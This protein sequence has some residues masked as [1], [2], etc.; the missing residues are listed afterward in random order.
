MA[1]TTW[2]LLCAALLSQLLSSGPA[3]ADTIVH[4][5]FFDGGV[6][7]WTDGLATLAFDLSADGDGF[8]GSG[9]ARIAKLS[10]HVWPE[11]LTQCVDGIQAG[12]TY[13]LEAKVAFAAGESAS[14]VVNSA[15]EFYDL[16]GCTGVPGVSASSPL[17]TTSDGRGKW[18]NLPIGNYKKGIQAG[19]YAQS[20]RIAIE[21]ATANGNTITANVDDVTLAQTGAP[22]CQG[23]SATIVGTKGA[24]HLVGTPG[25]DVI[26]GLGGDDEIDGRGG[27]DIIC[28]GGGVDTISG[29][30]GA[31]QIFGEGG[32]DIL[33][34]G[35]GDDTLVGGDGGDSLSGGRGHDEMDPGPGFDCWDGGADDPANDVGCDLL[36][37]P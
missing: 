6:I 33:K 12:G 3:A 7:G 2:T 1:R 29:G 24:D 18:L 15:I 4:N 32:N 9:S 20:A 23:F 19:A 8:D 22:L 10:N 16:P 14:A 34:G 5:G 30:S 11:M 31:D 27:N 25:D 36:F 35:S 21:L 13:F 17:R 28:G 37:F 26:V